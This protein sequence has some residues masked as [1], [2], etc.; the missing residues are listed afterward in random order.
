MEVAV[1]S[2]VGEM[3]LVLLAF[4][5]E[6]STEGTSCAVG[7]DWVRRAVCTLQTN[8]AMVVHVGADG[9]ELLFVVSDEEGALE[10]SFLNFACLFLSCFLD[11]LL[12]TMSWGGA[13]SFEG[14]GSSGGAM[15][16]GGAMSSG[17]VLIFALG[18]NWALC[19]LLSDM[20]VVLGEGCTRDTG[21][22]DEEHESWEEETAML[23]GPETWGSL[24]DGCIQAVVA[25]ASWIA[26]W[27]A[28]CGCIDVL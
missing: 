6:V 7:A 8:S 16:F 14:A 28:C 22:R 21:V 10:I 11:C 27:S 1:S 20:S 5:S 15:C 25:A 17:G 23:R 12:E 4:K 9:G 3:S 18:A 24:M 13:M 19:V 26:V 2:L